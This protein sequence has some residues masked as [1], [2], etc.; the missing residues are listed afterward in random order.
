M[1]ASL[2][3]DLA[4]IL[5]MALGNNA[6]EDQTEFDLKQVKLVVGPDDR[7]STGRKQS[8]LVGSQPTSLPFWREQMVV[9]P[10][11]SEPVSG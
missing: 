6:G 11:C 7:M 2:H 10:V 4:G 8:R 9:Q 5:N 1:L 3:G